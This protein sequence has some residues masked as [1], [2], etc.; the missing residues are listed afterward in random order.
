MEAAL[1][2][3]APLISGPVPPL[4]LQGDDDDRAAR[5]IVAFALSEQALEDRRKHSLRNSVERLGQRVNHFGI[6][7]SFIEALDDDRILVIL[8]GYKSFQQFPQPMEMTARLEV[9]IADRFADPC[10]PG[11]RTP[12]DKEVLRVGRGEAALVLHKRVELHS[13]DLVEV[14]VVRDKNA[15]TAIALRFNPQGQ[16]RLARATQSNIGQALAVILDGEVIAAAPIRAPIV[17]GT[18]LFSGGLTMERARGLAMLMRAG[19]LP[20]QLTVVEQQIVEPSPQ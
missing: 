4:V 16:D 12:P 8:P 20:A 11:G 6:G 9:R 7:E 3:F 18:V 2:A 17:D 10:A 13:Q 15:S 19:W 5:R 14:A 1:K